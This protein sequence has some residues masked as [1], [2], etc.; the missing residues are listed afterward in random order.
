MQ[1]SNSK[2]SLIFQRISVVGVSA[3][4]AAAAFVVVVVVVVSANDVATSI[5][6]QLES[7]F[8][9]GTKRPGTTFFNRS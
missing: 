9:L 3:S 5:D 1:F 8:L 6:S 4:A 7:A 2:D